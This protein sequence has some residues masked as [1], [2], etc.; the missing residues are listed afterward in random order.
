ML[1]QFLLDKRSD[2][3]SVHVFGDVRVGAQFVSQRPHFG[4]HL[5]NPLRRLDGV[6]VFLKRAACDT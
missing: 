3:G 6:A 1:C 2:H 4:K 5:F